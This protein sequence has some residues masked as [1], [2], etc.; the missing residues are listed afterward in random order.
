MTAAPP[1]GAWSRLRKKP[2]ALASSALLAFVIAFAFLGP[3]VFHADPHATSREQFVS[4]CAA[5]HLT[6]VIESEHHEG[7]QSWTWTPIRAP[8][9]T[10]SLT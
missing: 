1:P 7:R 6:D 2:V 4:P 5:H 8:A 10:R 3:L 9:L